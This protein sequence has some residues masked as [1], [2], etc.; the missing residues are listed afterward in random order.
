MR[1]NAERLANHEMK[2]QIVVR[3]PSV[4]GGETALGVAG[5]MRDDNT[6]AYA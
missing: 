5:Y 3:G 4:S 2:L 1:P 6:L